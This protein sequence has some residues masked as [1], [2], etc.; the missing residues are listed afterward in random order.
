M[1]LLARKE[2][3]DLLETLDRFGLQLSIGAQTALRAAAALGMLGIAIRA[4]R[5]AP[6]SLDRTILALGLL[7][8]TLFNPRSESVSYVALTPAFGLGAAAMLIRDARSP[9]GWGLLAAGV[10]LGVPWNRTID[11][12]LKPALALAYLL[13]IASSAIRGRGAPWFDRRATP[14]AAA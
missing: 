3:C 7:F 14:G 12:W 8:L 13:L 4:R 6:E 11:S 1:L 2:L 9:L 10:A 5:S